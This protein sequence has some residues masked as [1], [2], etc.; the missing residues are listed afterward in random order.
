MQQYGRIKQLRQSSNLS[1]QK[2]ADILEL[3]QQQYQRYES[4]IQEIPVHLLIKLADLYN[5]SIDYIVGRTD[6]I[7]SEEEN[8]G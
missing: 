2:V 6:E 3:K 7:N 4:G 5:V 1:Q 8:I